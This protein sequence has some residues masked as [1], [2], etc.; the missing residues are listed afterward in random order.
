MYLQIW[1]EFVWCGTE[2][3]GNLKRPP[4]TA[5]C[6]RLSSDTKPGLLQLNFQGSRS[7]T[8]GNSLPQ[9]YATIFLWNQN[10]NV[11]DREP[12]QSN[13][14]LQVILALGYKPCT[15]APSVLVCPILHKEK[16]EGFWAVYSTFLLWRCLNV[17]KGFCRVT[18]FHWW[19]L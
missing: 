9:V 6:L 12:A 10:M 19:A 14:F 8:L 5:W 17:C 1:K 15:P 2:P 16:S 4:V 18:T 3:S 11:S 13:I 7:L